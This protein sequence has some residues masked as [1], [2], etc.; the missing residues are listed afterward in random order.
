MRGYEKMESG[1]IGVSQRSYISLRSVGNSLRNWFIPENLNESKMAFI[2]WKEQ[3]WNKTAVISLSYWDSFLQE[4][5]SMWVFY[6][7][8]IPDVGS[9][10]SYGII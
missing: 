3:M 2:I 6:N 8:I 10:G 1:G 5:V 7:N 9:L 4:D